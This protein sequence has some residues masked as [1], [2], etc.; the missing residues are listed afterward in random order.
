MFSVIAGVI[1]GIPALFLHPM[2]GIAMLASAALSAAGLVRRRGD[3]L[4]LDVDTLQLRGVTFRRCD[5]ISCSRGWNGF[6]LRLC[7]GRSI[8]R[9]SLLEIRRKDV[10]RLEQAL[11]EYFGHK[12]DRANHA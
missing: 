1:A 5:V 9:I 8:L 10:A 7:D 11:E 12:F 4:V 2:F 6:R 3:Y